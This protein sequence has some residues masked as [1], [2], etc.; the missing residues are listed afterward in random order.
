MEVKED[1]EGRRKEAM[2]MRGRGVSVKEADVRGV[3]LVRGASV[4]RAWCERG[5]SREVLGIVCTIQA[6][7]DSFSLS[8]SLWDG[9]TQEQTEKKRT[10]IR[11]KS[12]CQTCQTDGGRNNK[13]VL[14]SGVPPKGLEARA[15][16]FGGTEGSMLGRRGWFD[17]F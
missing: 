4:V 13:E 11:G 7:P 5:A 17:V 1:G 8:C 14:A 15:F 12:A 3:S 6:S 9:R 2:C 10:Y 16:T